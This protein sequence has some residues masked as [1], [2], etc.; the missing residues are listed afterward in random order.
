M[1]TNTEFSTTNAAAIG[2][3]CRFQIY[4]RRFSPVQAQSVYPL[5]Q[6]REE[7]NSQSNFSSQNGHGRNRQ[8]GKECI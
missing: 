2:R 4:H 8:I 3:A 1:V 6:L 5:G 7:G